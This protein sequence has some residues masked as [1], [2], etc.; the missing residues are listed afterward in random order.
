MRHFPHLLAALLVVFIL[1]ATAAAQY[2]LSPEDAA[3]LD[4]G[5]AALLTA[6]ALTYNVNFDM[7]LSGGTLTAAGTGAYRAAGGGF[8]GIGGNP[9]GLQLDL[10]G[11][12]Q[13]FGRPNNF[14]TG[15]VIDGDML[16][17]RGLVGEGEWVSAPLSD[18]VGRSALTFQPPNIDPTFL[19]VTRLP[20]ATLNGE[21][22]AEYNLVY[23]LSNPTIQQAVTQ[24]SAD[25]PSLGGALATGAD[26]AAV[27]AEADLTV[28]QSISVDARQMRRMVIIYRDADTELTIEVDITRYGGNV[29]LDAPD[30]AAPLTSGDLVG[31]S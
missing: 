5:N 29:N 11:S 19:T 27:L 18:A 15:A 22:V 20:D 7:A 24:G 26:A 3:L 1:T 13:L 14:T 9:L 4:D 10:S 23:D 30:N 16:Y 6:D 25:M 2:G 8:L 17:I 21:V 12:S 31:P 28:V